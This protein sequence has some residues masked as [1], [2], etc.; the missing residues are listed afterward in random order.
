M[1]FRYT[2]AVQEVQDAATCQRTP[3]SFRIS[4]ESD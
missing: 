3:S 1:Q 4:R 2:A